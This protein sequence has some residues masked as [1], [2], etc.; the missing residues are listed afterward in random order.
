M[1]GDQNGTSMNVS[2]VEFTKVYLKNKEDVPAEMD[3][4]IKEFF[5]VK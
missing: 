4:G 5:K 1:A 3:K 2:I